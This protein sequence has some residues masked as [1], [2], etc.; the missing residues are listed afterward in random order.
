MH[1]IERIK[2][3]VKED[4][5]RICLP[6]STDVRMLQA[7]RDVA[8][9]G[10]AKVA[11][12]GDPG[13]IALAAK[14]AGVDISGV[15]LID[16]RK[17]EEFEAYVAAYHEK[18]KHKGVDEAKAREVI[19]DPLYF[20]ASLVKD[21]RQ[22][23][24][25]AGAVNATAN[26]L[27]STIHI[28]GLAPECRTLSSCFLMILPEGMQDFGYEGNLI[29]ADCGAVPNPN[30]EQL[31]DIA[32]AAAGSCRRLL[33][34]EPQVALL[35]F[36]TK[37]SAR[38]PDIDKVCEAVKILEERKVGFA[39]DGEM[40]ADAALIPSI[41]ERKCKGSPVA[42][43]ANTLIFP[44]L[45]AGNIAYKLTERLARAEAYG[46]IVQGGALPVNDLSRGCSARDIVNMVAITAAQAI[47]AKAEG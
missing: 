30:A 45:D 24:M 22:D 26:V 19:C 9:E 38:H 43:K 28:V 4:I 5:Q 33:G 18:R 7:A 44:D 12:I 46:P 10:T 37:G 13:E 29:Y 3:R 15:E 35:S 23:G 40:Q 41:G 34:V 39:F 42:G 17:D 47:G 11:L 2:A 1:T 14:E 36:S 16:H 20:G 31:A 25:V 32:I 6:E 8:A 21:G 27:R